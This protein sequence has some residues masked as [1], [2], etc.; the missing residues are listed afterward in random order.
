MAAALCC[1]ISSNGDLR[2]RI[3]RH[4]VVAFCA[5]TAIFNRRGSETLLEDFYH[6]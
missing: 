5:L 2:D 4:S 1:N 6:D 3:A